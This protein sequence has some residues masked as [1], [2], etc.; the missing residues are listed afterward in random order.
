MRQ[1]VT[2][3]RRS[4]FY[5]SNDVSAQES[6]GLLVAQ[7]LDEAVGFAD[8]LGSAVGDERELAD[9]VLHSLRKTAIGSKVSLWLF[10]VALNSQGNDDE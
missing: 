6:V 3:K 5:R 4:E 8:R 9:V 2:G 10:L 7:D 1:L